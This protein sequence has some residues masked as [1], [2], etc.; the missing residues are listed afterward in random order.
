[1]KKTVK[2]ILTQQVNKP[3]H[4]LN[5]DSLKS[6]HDLKEYVF[7]TPSGYRHFFV[8][9][10]DL[11]DA[12]ANFLRIDELKRKGFSLADLPIRVEYNEHKCKDWSMDDF[13]DNNENRESIG[14]NLAN[15][16]I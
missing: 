9:G 2:K 11:K 13:A 16:I 10:K 4:N 1:M 15:E 5:Y 3:E 8:L 7:L 14:V 12:E 6:E